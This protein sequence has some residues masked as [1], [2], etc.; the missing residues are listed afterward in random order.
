[1][2]TAVDDKLRHFVRG[3]NYAFRAL[4][5]W[6]RMDD[7][8]RAEIERRFRRHVSACQKLEIDPDPNWLI[9]AVLDA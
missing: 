9:E 3:N 2:M 8:E 7:R 1:M 6:Q 5:R 4:R